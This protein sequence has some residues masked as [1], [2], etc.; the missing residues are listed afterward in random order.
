MVLIESSGEL[1][2]CWWNFDSVEEDSFLSLEND[3]FGPLHKSGEVASWQYA[4]S[5]SEV[6]RSL[7]E[8]RIA[9]LFDFLA[10]FLDFLAFSLSD[11]IRTILDCKYYIKINIFN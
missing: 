7:F 8:E 6:A 3:V 1:S 5:D 10:S 4:V 9:L 2:N 11:D